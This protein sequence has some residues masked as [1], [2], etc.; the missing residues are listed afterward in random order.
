MSQAG[1]TDIERLTYL[2]GERRDRFAP[3]S[4]HVDS[5]LRPSILVVGVQSKPHPK[6][7]SKVVGLLFCKST[8]DQD[9]SF[10]Q[11]VVDLLLY[12]QDVIKG[13]QPSNMDTRTYE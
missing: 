9:I 13:I 6:I 11:E 1:Q 10:L 12:T 5:F 4:G 8:L 3:V 2:R 7:F